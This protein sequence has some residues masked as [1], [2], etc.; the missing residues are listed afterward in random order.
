MIPT[1]GPIQRPGSRDPD[2]TRSSL[3]PKP[4][5]LPDA[6]APRRQQGR[7]SSC[8]SRRRRVIQQPTRRAP[9]PSFPSFSSPVLF[10]RSSLWF[11]HCTLQQP[12]P[13]ARASHPDSSSTPPPIS[14]SPH[15]PP[16]FPRREPGR[17]AAPE[18]L[19]LELLLPSAA[20]R[21]QPQAPSSAN[22]WSRQD[23]P[24]APPTARFRATAPVSFFD[25][26]LQTP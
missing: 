20:P 11:S 22:D 3:T 25:V 8:R 16:S 9:R 17:G 5:C 13:P 2:A 15:R 24:R 1:T 10:P 7:R 19:L 26:V 14:P 4:S 23:L 21:P 18:L 6:L 12:L